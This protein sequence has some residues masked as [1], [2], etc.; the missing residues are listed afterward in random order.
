[1]KSIKR[2][3]KRWYLKFLRLLFYSS[4]SK[5]KLALGGAVGCFMGLTPTVGLQ[6]SLIT[7]SYTL[8]YFINKITHN[9]IKTLDFN[10]PLAIALT[11]LSNPFNAPFLYFFWYL[12]GTLFT[13]TESLLSFSDFI[14]T[15]QPLFEIKNLF[16]SLDQIGIYFEN[17]KSVLIILGSSILYP[18][19]IGSLI[20]AIPASIAFYFSLRWLLEHSKFA[21][22]RRVK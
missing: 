6:I 20:M 5:H 4:D 17:F 22:S 3:I 7:L 18:L 11:W 14:T 12:T 13:S 2:N 15:L 8:I 1:M 16:G 10:L 19:I 9:K 21:K